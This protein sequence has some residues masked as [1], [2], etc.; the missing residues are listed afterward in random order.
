[1]GRGSNGIKYL[2]KKVSIYY[3]CDGHCGY[4]GKKLEFNELTRDHIIP[5]S[6]GARQKDN[7]MPSCE[8]CN[9]LKGDLSLEHFRESICLIN[10]VFTRSSFFITCKTPIVFFYEKPP[11]YEYT[12]EAFEAAITKTL[13]QESLKRMYRVL[14]SL[15]DD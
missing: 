13:Y 7:L 15:G 10:G 4:C 8:R 6:T 9:R 11:E 2:R 5:Y 12:E 14:N 1:M 3:A